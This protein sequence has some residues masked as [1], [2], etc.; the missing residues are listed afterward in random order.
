MTDEKEKVT[1]TWRES[2][3]PPGEKSVELSEKDLEK[4]CGG[5]KTEP[6]DPC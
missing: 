5:G 6:P 3:K 1:E 4:A 2:N